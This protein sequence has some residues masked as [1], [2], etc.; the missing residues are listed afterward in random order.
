MLRKH[1]SDTFYSYRLGLVAPDGASYILKGQTKVYSEFGLDTFISRFCRKHDM[2]VDWED[3]RT[4]NDNTEYMHYGMMTTREGLHVFSLPRRS[5]STIF[6]D[7]IP[8]SKYT[9]E[10]YKTTKTKEVTTAPTA[11]TAKPKVAVTALPNLEEFLD[12]AKLTLLGDGWFP[13]PL[14]EYLTEKE[15]I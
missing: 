11:D 14:E 4:L 2:E 3:I 12:E 9:P 8:D 1:N 7:D 13:D 6:M 10:K 5:V 15:A